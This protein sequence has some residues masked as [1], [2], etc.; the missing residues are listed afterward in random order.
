MGQE[1][2]IKVPISRS[3]EKKVSNI[4]EMKA[5]KEDT[6]SNKMPIIDD[7]GTDRNSLENFLILPRTRMMMSNM[8]TQFKDMNLF[9]TEDPQV[10]RMVDKK[11]KLGISLDTADYRPDELRVSVTD[12]QIIIEGK[13]EERDGDDDVVLRRQFVRRYSVPRRIGAE[14]VTC[15]LSSDG[16]LVVTA[17]KG[18]DKVVDV[19]INQS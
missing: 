10:I 3:S 9:Q 12:A 5:A 4:T 11:D 18:V 1:S 14:Q 19:K 8:K 7:L 2:T 13:H 16:V 15:N 6:S 17:L